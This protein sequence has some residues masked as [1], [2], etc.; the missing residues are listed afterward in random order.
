MSLATLRICKAYVVAGLRRHMHTPTRN[1]DY[2]FIRLQRE[3]SQ[4]GAA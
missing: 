2:D 3:V 1:E 4:S